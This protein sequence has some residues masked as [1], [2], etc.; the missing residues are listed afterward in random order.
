MTTRQDDYNRRVAMGRSNA[1]AVEL[2]RRHCRH[3]RIEL[4][5]GN[6]WVGSA[7]GLPMGLMEVRCEHAAPP[8]SQGHHALELAIE[9]YPEKT[10][11]YASWRN[12]WTCSIGP[13][14]GPSRCLSRR[15]ARRGK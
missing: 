4:V 1:E 14:P 12:I 9:F 15:S 5:G 2:T 3:A 13:S 10:S 6:S 8:R 11:S 7:L